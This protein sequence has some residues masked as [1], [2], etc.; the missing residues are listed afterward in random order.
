[1]LHFKAWEEHPLVSIYHKQ[2]SGLL[3]GS[4]KFLH[5]CICRRS[6]ITPMFQVVQ[7]FIVVVIG[8]VQ[9]LLHL[10]K[11]RIYCCGAEGTFTKQ[12]NSGKHPNRKA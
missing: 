5:R 1:M 9:E 11:E 8:M 2:L 4:C 7:F 6:W 12:L 3:K 10:G